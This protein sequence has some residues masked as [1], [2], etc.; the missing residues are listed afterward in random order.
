MAIKQAARRW[1]IDL[2]WLEQNNRSLVVLATNCLCPSCRQRLWGGGGV[3]SAAEIMTSV[4]DC[5]SRAPEF[6]TGKL[7]VLESVFRLLLANGNQPLELAEL[8]KHL[9]ERRGD[10]PHRTPE[11]SLARLL[12]SDRYYGLRLA[13]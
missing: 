8:E 2:D 11:G 12:E 13:E 5:C 1:F 3:I 6:I 7:P 10:V 9:V 4:K